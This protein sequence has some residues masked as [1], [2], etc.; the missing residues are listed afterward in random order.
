MPVSIT[1]IQEDLTNRFVTDRKEIQS[2]LRKPTESE[3]YMSSVPGVK[4]KYISYSAEMG[5]VLQPYQ[6]AWTPTDTEAVEPMVASVFMLKIDKEYGNLE[7][8]EQTYAG[9]LVDEGMTMEEYPISKWLIKELFDKAREEIEE[10]CATASYAAPTPGTA[11]ASNTMFNGFLEILATEI[12]NSNITPVASGV[13]TSADIY[14]NFSFFIKNSPQHIVKKLIRDGQP[15]F[16]SDT[17]ATLLWEDYYDTHG[18]KTDFQRAVQPDGSFEILVGT[19][20]LRVKGLTSMNGSNRFL[21]LE[22]SN[23]RRLYDQ[24][25]LPNQVRIGYLKRKL[26][27]EGHFKRGYAYERGGDVLCND[28]A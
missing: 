16:M 15:F 4:D 12:T 9:W 5:Q 18:T 20:K 19:H 25:I 11:G 8:L 6:E 23:F 22:K 26:Y 17:N 21:G 7:K 13:Y 3:M 28:Q 27:L 10:N 1:Q 14:D 24:I 2:M